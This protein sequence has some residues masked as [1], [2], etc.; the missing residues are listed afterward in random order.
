[1]QRPPR[2]TSERMVSAGLLL[3]AL[4][5]L[6]ML[7]AVLS[8]AGYFYVQW[9]FT[10]HW[11]RSLVDEGPRYREATTMTLAGIVGCQVANAF[12]C[13]S[14]RQ[15]ALGPGFFGNVALFWAIVAEVAL[16]A[17][18][19]AVP[20]LRGLFELEPVRPA[21]WPLLVALPPLFLLAEEARKLVAR[22]LARALPA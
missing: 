20:S 22:R 14:E 2:A 12:A 11:F 17:L 1:M 8:L 19:I 13:R 18:V 10:G 15:S 6:G 7:A 9:D 3:R 4:G 16:L 21:Y 5:F